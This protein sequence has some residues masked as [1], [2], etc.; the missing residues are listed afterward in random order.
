MTNKLLVNGL[1]GLISRLGDDEKYAIVDAV[2]LSMGPDASDDFDLRYL[3]CAAREI[4]S[5]YADPRCISRLMEQDPDSHGPL[6]DP[7]PAAIAEA[8]A[9]GC[10]IDMT[11]DPQGL[12]AYLFGPTESPDAELAK[13]RL[14]ETLPVI[15]LTPED[16]WEVADMMTENLGDDDFTAEVRTA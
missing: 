10:L 7:D 13:I 8:R 5:R 12:Q 9:A 4:A 11:Y 16:V 3:S 14:A 15:G 1:M 6:P 2:I